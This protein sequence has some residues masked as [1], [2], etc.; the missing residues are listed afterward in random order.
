MS[1][2]LTEKSAAELLAEPKPIDAVAYAKKLHLKPKPKQPSPRGGGAYEARLDVTG[3][4]GHRFKIIVS[5]SL[6]LPNKFAVMLVFL[7]GKEKFRLV[8]C[9]G[10]HGPHT[11]YLE[12]KTGCGCTFIS[13]HTFH[14]HRFTERYYA[15]DPNK[16]D[17]YAEP[18][19]EFGSWTEALEYLSEVATFRLIGNSGLGADP[20]FKKRLY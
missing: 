3:I 15:S 9:H 5:V 13:P 4:R 8:D 7:T 2:H 16:H 20:L 10:W 19:D 18:T 6:H 17:W 12:A 1:F 11:N 14:I